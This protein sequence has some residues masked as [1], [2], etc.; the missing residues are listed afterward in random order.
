[1][2]TNTLH[3]MVSTN[4]KIIRVAL[5]N[6]LN[7]HLQGYRLESGRP[8]ELFE[9][10]GVRHG[11]ARIDIAVID[12]V[13]HGYEIKSDRDTLE[14]LPEQMNEFNAVFDKLSLV[15]GRRHLYDAINIVPDWWGIIV[16]KVDANHEIFFQTIR[17]AEDNQSQVGVSI[18]RLLW[19]EEALRI[20]E[21]RSKARGVRSKPR[22]FIY[23]RLADVLDADTLKEKV[24]DALLISRGDWR[25]GR[26]L[27]TSGDLY[28]MQSNLPFSQSL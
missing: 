8:A 5:R 21:E 9:E 22:E 2:E 17:E 13:M 12:G 15:V 3:K 7:K 4:D 18:A 19:K 16:A 6:V 10:F 23:Q 11:A 1:M 27:I 28:P 20:L 26:P 14:R 25:A 24:R